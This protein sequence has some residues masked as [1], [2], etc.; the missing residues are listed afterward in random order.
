M[1]GF[2]SIETTAN[3]PQRLLGKSNEREPLLKGSNDEENLPLE[4]KGPPPPPPAYSEVLN[5]QAVL[6][7]VVYTL[8]ALHNMGFDQLLPVYLSH[9]PLKSRIDSTAISIL[10]GGNPLKF[11]GGL[12]LNH[13]Q[14]GLITT[15]YGI[16]GMV[17]QFTLFP[18]F[19]RR[20]GVSNPWLK[21]NV[22]FEANSWKAELLQSENSAGDVAC[23][24]P[25]SWVIF[26]PSLS[27]N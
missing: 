16:C 26:T 4:P 23:W 15:V 27:C 9:R 25:R 10:T 8:L 24:S 14:I 3:Y 18:M 5:Q 1:H 22:V 13:L 17:I 6:N 21:N 2:L 20:F 12:G 19:A 11:A 7:L